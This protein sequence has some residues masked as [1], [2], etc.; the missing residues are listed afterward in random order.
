MCPVPCNGP[1]L[2]PDNLQT[3][4]S[5]KKKTINQT[6]TGSSMEL[7][8]S[9]KDCPRCVNCKNREI[10]EF[11]LLLAR[12]QVYTFHI[13]RKKSFFCE[14]C[15]PDPSYFRAFPPLHFLKQHVLI[16]ERV[17]SSQLAA[18]RIRKPLGSRLMDGIQYPESRIRNK[19]RLPDGAASFFSILET[20]FRVPRGL[21]RGSSLFMM[22][23]I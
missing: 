19:P 2:R 12:G 13:F 18:T 3:S 9:V 8:D 17:S 11:L 7:N 14:M 16:D 23:K 1:V 22:S 10:Q 6:H 21:P 15:R 4:R 20:E 5:G